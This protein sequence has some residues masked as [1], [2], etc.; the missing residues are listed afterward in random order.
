L[1][2]ENEGKEKRR[3]LRYNGKQSSTGKNVLVNSS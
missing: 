2:I 3:S 1:R